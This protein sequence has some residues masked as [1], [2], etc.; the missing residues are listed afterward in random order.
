M[1][2]KK[3]YITLICVLFACSL[4]AQDSFRERSNSWLRSEKVRKP[5]IDDV[6]L[7]EGGMKR[8]PVVPV[9][10]GTWT[11]IG[12]GL[13]YGTYLYTKKKSLSK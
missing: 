7:G 2:A 8:D 6:D 12:L 5:A 1:K 10:D 11:I 3:L 13:M 4:F 9:G